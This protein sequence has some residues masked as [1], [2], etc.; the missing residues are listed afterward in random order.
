MTLLYIFQQDLHGGNQKR[1]THLEQVS[2]SA[3]FG[4]ARITLS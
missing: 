2:L 4:E 3:V 1:L